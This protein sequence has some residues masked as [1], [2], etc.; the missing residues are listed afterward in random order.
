VGAPLPALIP[1]RLPQLEALDAKLD[2]ILAG[3]TG[4]TWYTLEQAWRLKFAGRAGEEGAV[5]LSSIKME[6]ALQPRGGIPDGWQSNRKTWKEESIEEWLLIDDAG[7]E[8]YLK[9]NNPG[10]RIP[11]RIVQALAKR[12]PVL[13]PAD[14]RGLGSL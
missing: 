13:M 6:R 8:A 14:H 7:L 1:I 3:R 12:G 2:A 4:Q 5:S 9:V 10:R 11:A